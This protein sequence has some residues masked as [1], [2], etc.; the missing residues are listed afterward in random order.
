MEFGEFGLGGNFGLRLLVPYSQDLE[1]GGGSLE[2]VGCIGSGS[3][4]R[5]FFLAF[6]EGLQ[7]KLLAVGAR[8]RVVDQGIFGGVFSFGLL[9]LLHEV[10]RVGSACWVG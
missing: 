10:R 9:E 7:S 4:F 1:K 6:R 8:S 5:H 2:G 3:V